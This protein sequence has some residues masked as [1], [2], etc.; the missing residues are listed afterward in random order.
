MSV[1]TAISALSVTAGSNEPDGNVETPA[2]VDDHLQQVYAFLAQLY[3]G[4]YLTSVAG[5]NTISASSSLSFEA[6]EEGQVFTFIAA[7][8]NTSAVTLNIETLGAIDIKIGSSDLAGGEMFAGSAVTV[9]YD[10]TD[11]QLLCVSDCAIGSRA[12]I[13]GDIIIRSGSTNAIKIANVSDVSTGA[14]ILFYESGLIASQA[15]IYLCIDSDNGSSNAKL[16]IA[17]DAN[18]SSATSIAQFL[19]AGDVLIGTSTSGLGLLRVLSST[20]IGL[21]I[22]NSATNATNKSGRFAVS[23]Y[24]NSQ[25]PFQVIGGSSTATEC[26]VHI[27]G[28]GSAA[29][30]ATNIQFYTDSLS[31]TAG[32]G[33]EQGYIGPSGNFYMYSVYSQTTA[34]AAN[35]FV[36][37]GGQLQ[38]STSSSEFKSDV[39]NMDLAVAKKLVNLFRAVYYRSTC[40]GDNK[41]WS[42]YGAIAEE[43]A[44]IDPRF[45][46]FGYANEDYSFVDEVVGMEEIPV[47]EEIEAENE[48]IEVVDNVAVVRKVKEKVKVHAAD[49]FP[50]VDESGNPVIREVSEGKFE[51]VFHVVHRFE[52]V[53]Q[54]ASRRTLKEGAQ[55]RPVGLM[56]ERFTVPLMMVAKDFEA[57]LSALEAVK[58]E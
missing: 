53:E 42:W 10:G 1:P 30:P 24:T 23:R 34:S 51:P 21:E 50:M 28:G 45:V 9:M 26:N 52:Q 13:Y 7:N 49:K 44:L 36:G 4:T 19:E 20:G 8:A 15:S 46:H 41:D 6:Y 54:K 55:L 29:A 17:N 48:Y 47:M 33:T 11:F 27:G 58:G 43:V 57:R 16:I 25:T 37:S 40:E 31:A 35:V 18:T 39:E 32:A 22:S 5:T 2:T 14:D 3:I 38:R 56:Y 12:R